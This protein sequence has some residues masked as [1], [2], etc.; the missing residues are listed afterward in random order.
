MRHWQ[1]LLPVFLASFVALCG[2]AAGQDIN[3]GLIGNWKLVEPS[4]TTAVDSSP[5]AN[6][7]TYMGSYTLATSPP[8]ANVGA[9]AETLNGT[10]GYVKINNEA[11]YD[12]TG[13]MSVSVWIK[14]NS[15]TIN[16]QAI[17]TKGDSAWAI[18]RKNKT[19]FLRFILTGPGQVQGN[20]SVN[21][22]L[23][24][25]VV[26]VYTGTQ[27]QL[28]VDGVLDQQ[29]NRKGAIATNDYQVNI[30]NNAEA[31]GRQFDG[32][33]YD[34]RIYNRALTAADIAVLGNQPLLTAH[35]K[36][37]E[38]SGTTAADS[39]G[40]FHTGTVTGTATWAN[41]ILNNGFQF[42][43]ST[44]IQAT[45]LLGNPKNVTLAAWANLTTADTGGSEIVSLGDHVAIR[46]DEGGVTKALFYN[47]TG[48]TSVNLA[49]SFVGGGWHHF[50][51][52]FDDNANLFK[53]YV[54]GVLAASLT[55]TDSISYAGLG[56][57][58][59]I[60]RQGN[61]GTANDF[62][63]TIDDVRVYNYALTP[64]EVAELYGFVGYWKLNQ[65]SGT[66]AT[67]ST[68]FARN[69]TVYGGA[70]WSTRCSGVGDFNF[71]GTSNYISIPNASNLQPTSSLTM[72]GWIRGDS[73]GSGSNVNAILR[74]GE[75][76]PN[77]Y[78]LAIADGRVTLYLNDSDS[79]GIRGNT[80]LNPDQWY[81]VAATWDGATAKIYVNGQL[82]NTPVA[83]ASTIGTDTRPLYIGGQPG[84]DQFK[85]S[86][87]DVR[88]FNRALTQSEINGFMGVGGYWKLDETSGT[89][90]ADASGKGLNGTIVG[91]P[92]WAAG[93]IDGAVYLDGNTKVE[94][95]SV[96]GAPR[97]VTFTAW[98]NLDARDGNGSEVVSIG[99]YFA[100][101]LDNTPTSSYAFFYNGTDWTTLSFN[102]SFEGR[103]WH[104]FAVVFNDDDNTFTIYVDGIQA[105]I[106]N[107]SQSV[108][109]T[110]LGTTTAIGRHGNNQ[111]AFDFTG[112]IDD[113]H[114]YTCALCPEDIQE[115][116]GDSGFGGVRILK[117][118]EVQ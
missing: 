32:S 97:N 100:L 28:Y 60:G 58:T 57:N 1:L 117:W 72:A 70:N 77:N 40:F 112:R 107:T 79:A 63:G 44:K 2:P 80:V 39:S 42:N 101:R 4:G 48:Y 67:D 74:K 37:N 45:G 106:M 3:T 110:G 78:Q 54:D 103:G 92:S 49:Q 33:I 76:N 96:F 41:G 75:A 35:W 71:N 116:Y 109:W 65:V 55:T 43:G 94:I 20:I 11:P 18:E 34:V 69:G 16:S 88:L 66:T 27:M 23:W 118:Q 50:A 68:I 14:I 10:T 114:I 62:T 53:L 5:S 26:G 87:Y 56:T 19:D 95:N 21:D 30:G 8:V 85:G 36:L 99:D 64:L 17:V 51:A 13:P 24:H 6:N 111:T 83:H 12:L 81:H 86:M 38:T 52:T 46:L 22:G 25:H 29:N 104:F 105:A 9:V 90:A 91:T 61:G 7:G 82:D 93:K 84:S 115:L 31:A 108:V 73:W 98:A 89:M 102:Q 15:F 59:V 47:G 113:V